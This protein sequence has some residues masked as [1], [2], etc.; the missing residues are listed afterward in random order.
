[1]VNK[2]NALQVNCPDNT[3]PLQMVIPHDGD[4]L[5]TIIENKLSWRIKTFVIKM[6]FFTKV[7]LYRL[8]NTI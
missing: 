5:A 7:K 3:A 2:A 1:M 6:I 4:A 8:E